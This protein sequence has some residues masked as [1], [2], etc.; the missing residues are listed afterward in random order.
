MVNK[1]PFKELSSTQSTCLFWREFLLK[2]VL[3]EHV[4]CRLGQ[5]NVPPEPTIL[6]QVRSRE[7]RW[8]IGAMFVTMSSGGGGDCPGTAAVIWWPGCFRCKLS[9]PSGAALASASFTRLN[10]SSLWL[11]PGNQT[12][13]EYIPFFVFR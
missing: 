3:A 13:F 5:P 8:T 7:R 9:R 6:G 1:C 12:S 11:I 2:K 4:I 10:P